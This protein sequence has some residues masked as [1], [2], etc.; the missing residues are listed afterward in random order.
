MMSPAKLFRRNQ[1]ERQER[2]AF[3]DWV[4]FNPHVR[5]HLIAIPNEGKRNIIS[6]VNLK[7]MGMIAGVPDYFLM[8]PTKQYHGLWLEFKAGKNKLTQSQEAFFATAKHQGY[9]CT[10]VYSAKEAIDEIK[11]YLKS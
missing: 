8:I 11:R 6:A 10:V 2:M 7:R 4:R 9:E 3:M 5:Y 1:P